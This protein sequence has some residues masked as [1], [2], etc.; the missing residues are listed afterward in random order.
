MAGPSR[1]LGKGKKKQP[2]A[3]DSESISL[4]ALQ[5]LNQQSRQAYGKATRTI[6]AYASYIAKGK[7]FLALTVKARREKGKA[8]EKDGIDTNLLAKAFERPPNKLSA[9][10]FELFLV[11]KCLGSQECGPSTAEGIH[12]AFCD[13][14]DNM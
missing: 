13:Y 9:T 7:E 11:H 1:A 8:I 10:A 2:S 12:A 3:S 5:E 4:A 14:W 6:E